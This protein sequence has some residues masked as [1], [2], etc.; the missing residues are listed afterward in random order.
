M[1]YCHPPLVEQ[2]VEEVRSLVGVVEGEMV[3]HS[4]P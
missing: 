2:V 4:D 3:E 1:K